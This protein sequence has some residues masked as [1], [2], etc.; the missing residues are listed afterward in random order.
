MV[1]QHF[2][3]DPT[4]PPATTHAADPPQ[5]TGAVPDILHTCCTKVGLLHEG[6]DLLDEGCAY[7]TTAPATWS[8]PIP[9]LVAP[10]PRAVTSG[11][12]GGIGT[13][14]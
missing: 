12:A 14:P 6:G 9:P 2:C 5:P 4:V 1:S 10:G 13:A 8:R 3:P 7:C 11:C